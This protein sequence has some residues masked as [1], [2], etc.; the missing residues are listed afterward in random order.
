MVGYFQDDNGNKSISRVMFTI[1]LVWSMILTTYVIVF[2]MGSIT[3]GLALFT[4][5]STLFTGLKLIQK[6]IEKPATPAN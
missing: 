1:G 3:E 5:T 6:Q 2:K 4:A